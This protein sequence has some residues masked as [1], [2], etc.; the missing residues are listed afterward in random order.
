M[1]KSARRVI[2]QRIKPSISEVTMS[3][4][5]WLNIERASKIRID[6]KTRKKLLD[7]TRLYASCLRPPNTVRPIL[8]V[9][10]AS[11][12][13]LKQTV[14]LRNIIWKK[15]HTD[16]ARE[17]R[18]F[19]RSLKAFYGS[20]YKFEANVSVLVDRYFVKQPTALELKHPTA[21]FDRLLKGMELINH[22][23]IMKLDVEAERAREY[24]PWFLWAALV[25]V[26]LREN[27]IPVKHPARKQLLNGPVVI[28]HRL[29]LK[30][31]TMFQRRRSN[32]S[33]RKAAVAAWKLRSGL[34]SRKLRTVLSRWSKADF[35][36]R[37][38]IGFETIIDVRL[39]ELAGHED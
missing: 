35:R 13:L 23:F 18:E 20:D 6:V 12:K 28:L 5:E 36:K 33:L 15:D 17:K 39:S 32:A 2:V 24:R 30:L 16:T 7:A 11:K 3:D 37:K 27:K 19:E 9:Q 21:F 25:L 8:D 22:Y 26:I 38:L 34:H 14:T 4:A 10:I 31:P 29:Q 1:S